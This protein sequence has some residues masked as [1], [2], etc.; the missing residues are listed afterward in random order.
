ML[1]FRPGLVA[2]DLYQTWATYFIA[3]GNVQ[4]FWGTLA[5]VLTT[6]DLDK[7]GL[8]GKWMKVDELKS[9]GVIPTMGPNPFMSI[10]EAEMGQLMGLVSKSQGALE[11]FATTGL[12]LSGQEAIFELMHATIY[13]DREQHI[14]KALTQ[15]QESKITKKQAYDDIK[16]NLYPKSVQ[17]AFDRLV[18]HGEFERATRELAQTTSAQFAVIYGLANLP[19][20]WRT[21]FGRLLGQ[22]NTWTT[23]ERGTITWLLQGAKSPKEAAGMA[24]RYAMT[25]A[26]LLGLNRSIGL[27]VTPWALHNALIPQV[28]PVIAGYESLLDPTESTTWNDWDDFKDF[29]LR[30]VGFAADWTVRAQ[31]LQERAFNPAAVW[32]RRLGFPIDKTRQS[33]LDEYMDHIPKVTKKRGVLPSIRN[34]VGRE[35]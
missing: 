29:L 24:A 2:R 10:P 3:F 22:F 14:G 9:R 1:G 18:S 5:D 27:S 33:W 26:I 30:R 6:V 17:Q 4:D 19:E 28:G 7:K 15:M 31:D 16:I 11:K 32:A 34:L 8:A 25:Q 21:N 20:A 12:Y 23:W 35:R 13:L